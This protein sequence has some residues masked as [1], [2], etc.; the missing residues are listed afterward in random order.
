[1]LLL[2]GTGIESII[3]CDDCEKIY[4]WADRAVQIDQEPKNADDGS[5][6]LAARNTRID[7]MGL[8]TGLEVGSPPCLIE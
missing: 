8:E 2:E 1:M 5:C 6:L 4:L 7:L 3:K